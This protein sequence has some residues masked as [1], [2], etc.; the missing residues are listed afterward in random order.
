MAALPLCQL[1]DCLEEDV[2]TR[3]TVTFGAQ[4]THL[5]LRAREGCRTG[6]RLT[7]YL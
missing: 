6:G 1:E 5:V 2:S 3:V 7:F 4:C